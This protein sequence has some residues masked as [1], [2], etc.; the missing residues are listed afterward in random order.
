MT[1]I[2]M[3]SALNAKLRKEKEGWGG[4]E[5]ERERERER[6]IEREREGCRDG[7]N[8]QYYYSTSA[9]YWRRN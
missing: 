5:T 9:R 2:H 4:R 1:P 8:I 3:A 7:W 6:K